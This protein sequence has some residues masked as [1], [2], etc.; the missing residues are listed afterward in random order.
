MDVEYLL[1]LFL[2]YPL[3]FY[4]LV[5]NNKMNEKLFENEEIYSIEPKHIIS[6]KIKFDFSDLI[7]FNRN[8]SKYVIESV[9]LGDTIPREYIDEISIEIGGYSV[10]KLY[11]DKYDNFIDLYEVENECKNISMNFYD[12]NNVTFTNI[13]CD[14]LQTFLPLLTFYDIS[15]II[16]L[17]EEYKEYKEHCLVMIKYSKYKNNINNGEFVYKYNKININDNKVTLTI[18]NLEVKL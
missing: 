4:N 2:Y 17:K 14:M 16:K 8:I 18:N 9:K 13:P 10:L 3:L 15:L 12:K 6:D 1:I 5:F 11:Y 7:G